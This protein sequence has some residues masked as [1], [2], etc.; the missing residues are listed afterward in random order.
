MFDAKRGEKGEYPCGWYKK[1]MSDWFECSNNQ[2]VP[3]CYQRRSATSGSGY[4]NRTRKDK[5]QDPCNN[6]VLDA[7]LRAGSVSTM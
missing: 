7:Y 1:E 5:D 3:I 4:H 6:R 2:F